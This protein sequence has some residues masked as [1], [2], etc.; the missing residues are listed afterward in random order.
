MGNTLSGSPSGGQPQKQEVPLKG[1]EAMI[2]GMGTEWPSR[3]I[4][5]EELNEYASKIYSDNPPWYVNI[6]P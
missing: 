4:V 2:T 3:L 1:D 5:P 6:T